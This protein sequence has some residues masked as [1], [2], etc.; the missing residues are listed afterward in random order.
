MRENRQDRPNVA[1]Q[2]IRAPNKKGDQY[3]LFYNGV[4]YGRAS[5]GSAWICGL[6]QNAEYRN[7][8]ALVNTEEI[9]NSTS[10]FEMKIYD[11]SGESEP[12]TKSVTL[13]PRRGTQENGILGSINQGYVQVRKVSGNNPLITYGVINDG[14]RLWERSSDGAF[15]LSQKWPFAPEKGKF[16]A[17]SPFLLCLVRQLQ[18]LPVVALRPD[19]HLDQS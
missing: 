14:G 6:Q 12:K 18:Y 19:G 8:L 15:L 13:G 5:V 1:F 11:G 16:L 17:F 9:D 3:S 10:N 2:H 7:N 4:F